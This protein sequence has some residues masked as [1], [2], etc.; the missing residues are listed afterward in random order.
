MILSACH[1]GELVIEEVESFYMFLRSC[2]STIA[3][4]EFLRSITREIVADGSVHPMESYR[5]KQAFERVVP[6]EARGVVSTHLEDIGLPPPWDREEDPPWRHAG[7]TA[8]QIEFIVNLGGKCTPGMSKGDASDLIEQL[9]ERRP[10]TPRQVMLLRFFNRMDLLSA[11]KEQVSVWID[12]LYSSKPE[13]E[14]A[15][16][17]FKLQKGIDPFVT[18]PDCVPIGAY[19]R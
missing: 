7:A 9:L 12:D 3:A 1:D 4:V 13:C 19:N 10:P 8:A 16:D 18:D 11:T 15:W 6:K 5:L 17:R 14:R 2:E